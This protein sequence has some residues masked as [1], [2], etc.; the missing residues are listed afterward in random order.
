MAVIDIH[1]GHAG[2]FM[3][4]YVGKYASAWVAI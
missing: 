4:V 3:F 1:H 2:M